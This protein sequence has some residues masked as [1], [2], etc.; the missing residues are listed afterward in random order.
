M[1]REIK[2][3]K[4]I[5]GVTFVSAMKVD[6]MWDGGIR[7]K[8]YEGVRNKY[9]GEWEI[10]EITP[11]YRT[12]ACLAMPGLIW[13]EIDSFPNMMQCYRFIKENLERML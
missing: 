13:Q 6:Q 9:T 11:W 8:K 10:D 1:K 2:I 4:D 3:E 5:F 7:K 12:R